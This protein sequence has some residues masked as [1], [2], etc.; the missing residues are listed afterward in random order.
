MDTYKAI[1]NRRPSHRI[2]PCWQDVRNFLPKHT[3][4]QQL[5]IT[6]WWC[7]KLPGNHARNPILK[8]ALKK[9]I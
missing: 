8:R 9:D 3:D 4:I 6:L 1:T 5:M 2:R 7:N